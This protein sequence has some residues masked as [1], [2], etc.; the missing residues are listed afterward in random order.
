MGEI[1]AFVANTDTRMPRVRNLRCRS[2][3]IDDPSETFT[4]V[5]YFDG[6]ESFSS[7]VEFT[8]AQPLD[9]FWFETGTGTAM[10]GV[11]TLDAASARFIGDRRTREVVIEPVP[12]HP[13]IRRFTIFFKGNEA[14]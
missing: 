10:I 2:W 8:G 14:A 3:V 11:T 4:V 6:R 12:G 9:P 13:S 1:C 5:E 7:S